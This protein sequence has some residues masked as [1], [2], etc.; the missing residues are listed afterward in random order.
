MP[1][2]LFGL[3]PFRAALT[4]KVYLA[5]YFHKHIQKIPGFEVGP[6]PD[7][8]VVLFRFIPRVGDVN[9]FNRTLVKTL[10]KD[11]KIYISTTTIEGHYYL[12][13]AVCVYRTHLQDVELCLQILTDY[14]ERV[15]YKQHKPLFSTFPKYPQ[16][17]WG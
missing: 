6:F 2:K 3:K 17:I 16:Q 10:L 15:A 1:L 8:S 14:S 13:L 7:I 9:E 4:E 11:G 12:R 5:R